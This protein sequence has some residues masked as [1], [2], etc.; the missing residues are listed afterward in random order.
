MSMF[1]EVTIAMPHDQAID[2]KVRGS[3]F[4]T[5]EFENMMWRYEISADGRLI[6]HAS[7]LEKLPD[8]ECEYYGTPEWE[9]CGIYQLIGSFKTVEH[10]I[11]DLNYHGDVVFYR[12]FG[13]R[14]DGDYEWF[15]YKARFTDGNLVWIKRVEGAL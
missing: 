15:E 14:D 12:S 5:K 2:D 6:E 10:P 9:K 8:E 4:Q 11:V 7:H 1:D 3:V 13:N